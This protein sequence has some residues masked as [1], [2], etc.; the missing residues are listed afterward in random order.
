MR[1]TTAVLPI[2]FPF[3]VFALGCQHGAMLPSAP[4][5]I[6]SSGSSLGIQPTILT[7]APHIDSLLRK[8]SASTHA[9]SSPKMSRENVPSHSSSQ[10]ASLR[11][12][13]T[14]EAEFFRHRRKTSV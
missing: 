13:E 1:P 4:V 3:F 2:V 6:A 5:T 12:V 14:F 11:K 7:S 9:R 8:A 10:A